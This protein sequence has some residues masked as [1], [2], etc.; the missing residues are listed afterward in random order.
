[1]QELEQMIKELTGNHEE[2]A[3]ENGDGTA[4]VVYWRLDDDK[5]DSVGFDAAD[6][7]ESDEASL[8]P[9]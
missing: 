5:V 9:S 8:S 1:M 7:D 6:S 2:M 4:S 3:V